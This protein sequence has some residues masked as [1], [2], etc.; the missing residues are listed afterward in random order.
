MLRIWPALA[1]FESGGDEP[2]EVVG[3]WDL[4]KAGK[5]ILPYSLQ[6]KLKP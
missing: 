2:R 3:R 5:W 1:V 4:E 6:K